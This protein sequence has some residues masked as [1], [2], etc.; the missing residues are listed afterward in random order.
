MTAIQD[1]N[2]HGNY[3]LSIDWEAINTAVDGGNAQTNDGMLIEYLLYHLICA[4]A[5]C[6]RGFNAVQKSLEEPTQNHFA[7]SI[8][9]GGEWRGTV[10]FEVDTSELPI[11]TGS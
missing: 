5:N 6:E 8:A 3:P 1:Y 7:E 2:T 9:E 11:A 10:K 4:A